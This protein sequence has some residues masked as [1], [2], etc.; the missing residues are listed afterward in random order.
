M[1]E[2]I[3]S[4]IPSSLELGQSFI[5][6]DS[7]GSWDIVDGFWCCHLKRLKKMLGKKVVGVNWRREI[8]VAAADVDMKEEKKALLFIIVAVCRNAKNTKTKPGRCVQPRSLQ[9]RSNR[10]L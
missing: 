2:K 10:L 4:N 8:D 7:M 3:Q 9:N 5:G 1:K 6:D